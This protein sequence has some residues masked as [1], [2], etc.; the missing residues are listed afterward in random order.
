[1]K[2]NFKN[3]ILLLALL[4]IDQVSKYFV[5][6]ELSEIES[7]PIIEGFFHLTYVENRGAA[8]GMMQGKSLLFIVATMVAIIA[9]LVYYN[10]QKN[11]NG[12]HLKTLG[13]IILFIIAGAIGNLIDRVWLGFVTDFI[14][15]RG[16]WKFVF[17]IAD[18]YVVCATILLGIYVVKYDKST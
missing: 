10:I 1:M 6:L 4:L 11:N 7:L 18:M 16:I 13:Y 5:R 17:N 12:P 14:D 8:F 9:L 2:S 3:I 15:F